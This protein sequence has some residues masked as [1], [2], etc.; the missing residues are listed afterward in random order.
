MSTTKAPAAADI[1]VEVMPEAPASLKK[2]KTVRLNEEPPPRYSADHRFLSEVIF[3][4]SPSILPR[5]LRKFDVWIATL[6]HIGLFVVDQLW[7][8]GQLTQVQDVNGTWVNQPQSTGYFSS[9]NV[10]LSFGYIGQCVWLMVFT[11]TFFSGQCY[12]RYNALYG[13]CKG[14]GGNLLMI[15]TKLAVDFESMPDERWDVVR[16]MAASILLVYSS[17]RSDEVVKDR[18]WERLTMTEQSFIGNDVCVNP[19]KPV[20]CPPL[21]TQAEVAIVKEHT[22]SKVVLLQVWALRKAAIGYEKIGITR[23]FIPIEE[24]IKK[25]RGCGSH[26]ANTMALP[27][28]FPY[29]HI[30]VLIMVLNYGFFG[31]AFLNMNSWLSPLLVFLVTTLFSG[32]RELA[33]ALSDPFG[34][35]AQ[36]FPVDKYMSACRTTSAALCIDP[37]MAPGDTPT[38][39]EDIKAVAMRTSVTGAMSK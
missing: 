20:N 5:T 37:P 32:V 11:L 35:D 10:I 23:A 28:P 25:I 15:C 38:K 16:Y 19:G 18:V 9:V 33:S 29:Y 3:Q 36:D 27:I 12:T 17:I 14:M 4:W 13:S 6:F 39:V 34:E 26:I 8:A 22:G 7:R 24:Q 21:L 2:R 1:K 31:F 30:L